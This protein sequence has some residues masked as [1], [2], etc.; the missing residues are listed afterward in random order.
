MINNISIKIISSLK[1]IYHHDTLPEDEYLYF[2]ML[3]NERKSFQI[4]VET[5]ESFTGIIDIDSALPS[6]FKNEYLYLGIHT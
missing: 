2:S 6:A 3:R 4:I 5:N 1:K